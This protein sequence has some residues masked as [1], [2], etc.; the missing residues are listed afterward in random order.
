MKKETIKN[1]DG[2]LTTIIDHDLEDGLKISSLNQRIYL[3]KYNGY[4]AYDEQFFWL[5]MEYSNLLNIENYDLEKQDITR[6]IY[7]ACFIGNNGYLTDSEGIMTKKR[8]KKKM[9]LTDKVF[10]DLYNK[11]IDYDILIEKENKLFI[12]EDLFSRGKLSGLIKK[13]NDYTRI[14][15]ESI[16]YIYENVSSKNHAMLGTFFK[17]IPFVHRTTNT[18]CLNPESPISEIIPM[19][20]SDLSKIVDYRKG[21]HDFIRELLKIRI[22]GDESLIGF[23]RTTEDEGLSNM[24]INPKIIY[25]GKLEDRF[26][27][28]ESYMFKIKTLPAIRNRK[29]NSE[30]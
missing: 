4:R 16:K 13:E 29:N 3:S 14:Y 27:E 24:K 6:L 22:N 30:L 20:V 19:T 26:L 11:L 10:Y 18:I 1:K 15:T 2:S 8:L 12:K 17:I 25:G 28:K 21:I 5:Y 23:W 7:I 9:N